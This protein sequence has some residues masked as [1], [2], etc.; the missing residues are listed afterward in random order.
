M[1]KSRFT[2]SQIMAALKRVEA[3]LPIPEICRDLG[4]ST[5]TFYK[6]RAKFGGMDSAPDTAQ[7]A[8][9]HPISSKGPEQA[10]QTTQVCRLRRLKIC[11]ILALMWLDFLSVQKRIVGCLASLDTLITAATQELDTLK[12]H[13]KGLM[14]QIFPQTSSEAVA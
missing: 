12:T 4:I 2:D 1:K 11:P 7:N 9:N 5:A 13:K 8:S 10:P 14:Q 6:W 3:G